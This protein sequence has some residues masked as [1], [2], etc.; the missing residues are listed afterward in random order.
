ML[1]A[2]GRL[3][4]WMFGYMWLLLLFPNSLT[5]QSSN[6]ITVQSSPQWGNEGGLLTTQTTNRWFTTND[7]LP[8]MQ[9]E[10]VWQDSKGY[11]FIGTLSGF[12]RY[13]GRTFTP[14]LK[15]RRENIVGFKEVG[16]RVRA[17]SFCRQWV[18]DGG[19]AASVAYANGKRSFFNNFN[20]TYLPDD[21]M[22]MEDKYEQN[23]QLVTLDGNELRPGIR[24]CLLDLMTPDRKMHITDRGFY[25]PTEQGL[26]F[27]ERI[28]HP[29]P[30]PKG[31]ELARSKGQGAGS[32]VHRAYKITPKA[33]IYTLCGSG[34]SLMVLA[35]DGI[36]RLAQGRLTLI[37]AFAF[38]S[39]DYGLLYAKAADGQLIIAD[40]HTV[41][42][43]D[44]NQMVTIADGFK[45]IKSLLV[46]RWGRLWVGTYEGAYCFFNMV[47]ANHRLTDGSDIMRAMAAADD[48]TLVAGT[49][50]GKLLAINTRTGKADIIDR[51]EGGY[52]LPSA[53]RLAGKV[54][55]AG[56]GDV[57]C[58]EGRK[59]SWLGLPDGQYQFVGRYRDRLIIGTR[60]ALLSYDPG[61]RNTDT[62]T[63]DILHPWAAVE[64]AR[65]SLWVG[66]STGLFKVVPA[67]GRGYTAQHIDYQQKLVVTAMAGDRAGNVVFA[68]ADSLLL[69]RDGKIE[70]LT[71]RMPQLKGHEIRTLYVSPRGYL[72]VAAVD[73][74]FVAAID[75]GYNISDIRFYD[76]GNG[77]TAIEALKATVA[78]TADGR[79]WMAGIREATSFDPA[80]LLAYS[81]Q[82]TIIP[83]PPQWWQHW[84]VWLA[85]LA[86]LGMMIWSVVYQI[87]TRR[88]LHAM[89]Q[90]EREKK[91]KELQI[92]SIRLKSIPHFHSNVLS[93]IEYYILNNSPE[94]ASRYLKLYS[95]FTNQ[96]LSDLDR[97]ARTINEEVDYVRAYMELEKMR[98]GD[99]LHYDIQISDDVDRNILIPNMLL[100]TYCQNAVKH[101]ISNK[102]E[103]GNVEIMIRKAEKPYL[104]V[105]VKDNGVGRKAAQNYN[106][107]STKQGM[108]ILLEQIELFNQNNEYHITQNVIDLY[109]DRGEPIGTCCE[110][111]IP[112]NYRYE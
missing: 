85:A 75:S 94:E 44:G 43:Y 40:A 90:L 76:H 33:D 109:D 103:G 16:G 92:N 91:Q 104:S 5:A 24:S 37:K 29:R 67:K 108:K 86:V 17:L 3:M 34:D 79:V 71:C 101:G 60:Q 52:Y 32:M 99:K 2:S 102:R 13:D 26:Y 106:R 35:G 50:N 87:V 39:P 112:Y 74:L 4:V 21:M 10:H 89:Q 27:I 59:L 28:A 110:M 82:Q 51:R 58:V 45:L 69:I 61:T 9:V 68:S 15:G 8:Q 30:L 7:G 72:I 107:Q 18:V 42:R 93:S 78:E 73:G 81:K 25:L 63:T 65:G 111:K 83:T 96:T 11:I 64:D 70:D 19:K 31:G 66:A 55:M 23:R 47:F 100:H 105:S 36:Y 1:R 98:F 54:Y 97:P 38:P 46:D 48:S 88:S 56:N 22:L 62:V 57:A 49:L 14:F 77:F 53:V 12:V 20:S 95:D 84:Y 41:Y 6:P 80:Q